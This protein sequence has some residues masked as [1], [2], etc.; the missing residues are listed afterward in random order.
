MHY[1]YVKEIQNFYYLS[2]LCILIQN[3]KFLCQI[4]T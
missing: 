2:L 4:A 3:I 1:Q